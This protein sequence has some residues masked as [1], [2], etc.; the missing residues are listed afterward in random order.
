MSLT[1]DATSCGSLLKKV[2]HRLLLPL[3]S[4]AKSDE[5]LRILEGFELLNELI[6]RVNDK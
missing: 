6:N 3:V 4:K 2:R 1:D 5:L